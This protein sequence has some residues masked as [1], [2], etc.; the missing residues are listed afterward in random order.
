MGSGIFGLLSTSILGEIGDSLPRASDRYTYIVS[1]PN[2][3]HSVGRGGVQ[4][5]REATGGE[6]IE[7]WEQAMQAP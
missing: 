5:L 3:Y 7:E 2:M 6:R 4:T 1:V